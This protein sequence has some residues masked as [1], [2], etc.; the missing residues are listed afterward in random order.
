MHTIYQFEI[1]ML[2]FECDTYLHCQ[3]LPA[4]MVFE[5]YEENQEIWK[6]KSL[7]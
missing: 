1:T 2:C 5:L 3:R 4:K 7:F 6:G